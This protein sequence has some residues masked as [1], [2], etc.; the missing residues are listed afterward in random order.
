M[1]DQRIT[2][3]LLTIIAAPIVVMVLKWL[4]FIFI[5]LVYAMFITLLFIPTL[6]KL[7]R[8]GIHKIIRVL[9]AILFILLVGFSLFHLIRLTSQE[10]LATKQ[11]FVDQLHIRLAELNSYALDNFGFS[12]MDGVMQG[13]EIRSEWIIQNL[14]SFSVFLIDAIPQ[15]LTT[16]FFVILLLFESFD[17]ERMLNT[18]ILKRRFSSIKTFQRIEK[19]IVTF[20]QVKFLI[21]LGTGIG[22]SVMCYAFDVSF[23]IFWGVFAFGI[24]FVQMV[25]SI[26]TIV[27]CSLFAFVELEVSSTLFYFILSITSVQVVFGSILEPIFMGKSF[28]I[29]IIVVLSMLMFWGFVWGIP[30]MILSIPLTVFIKIILEQFDKTKRIAQ[31]MK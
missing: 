24:N 21:S 9:S 31:L 10:I 26:I 16:L 17:F 5:P 4:D 15:L 28:S 30:G 6:R 14:K 13:E 20:L 11:T 12:V 7:K 27:L 22:T 19:D 23:P 3:I 25:G 1:S 29:N 18:T 8:R 2:N